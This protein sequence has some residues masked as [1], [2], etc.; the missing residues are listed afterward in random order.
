MHMFVLFRLPSCAQSAYVAAVRVASQQGLHGVRVC[1]LVKTTTSTGSIPCPNNQPHSDAKE[2]GC[3]YNIMYNSYVC[4]CHR[5]SRDK[6]YG[7]TA[8]TAYLQ[9]SSAPTSVFP[10][11][12][13]C[14]SGGAHY[15]SYHYYY[16]YYYYYYCYYCYYYCYYYY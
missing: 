15:Y 3:T 2:R 16:Y 13:P 6:Y 9:T 1:R 4:C 10:L 5:L 12:R 7:T 14:V 11:P 8:T